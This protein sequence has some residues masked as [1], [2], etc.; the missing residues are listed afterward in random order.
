MKITMKFIYIALALVAVALD[1]LRANAASG[2]LFASVDGGFVYKYPPS[3]V[4]NTFAAGLNAA[5][6]VDF[7]SSGNLFVVTFFCDT[8]CQTNIIKI[9]PDG[10]QSTFAS[11]AGDHGY[12]LEFD[13][14]GNLYTTVNFDTLEASQIW[15]YLPDGTPSLFA[16][17]SSALYVFFDLA[18]D[19]FGNLFVSTQSGAQQP[20]TILK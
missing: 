5:R 19:R 4:Q 2:D 12:G 3:G 13:S 16:T 6:G 7:D 11:A 14:A 1:T 20:D 10:V 18:F 8:S 9:T 17:A 15:K